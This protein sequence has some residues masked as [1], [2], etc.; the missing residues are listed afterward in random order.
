[1]GA[2]SCPRFLTPRSQRETAEG[3]WRG[4]RG[5]PRGVAAINVSRILSESLISEKEPR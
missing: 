1:M 3:G 4:G 2:A 5:G